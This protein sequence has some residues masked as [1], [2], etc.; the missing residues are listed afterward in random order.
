MSLA[1]INIQDAGQGVRFYGQIDFPTEQPSPAEQVAFY[2]AAH[3]EQIAKE[4][5][6]WYSA[7]RVALKTLT[8]E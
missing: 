3:H 1:R 8:K 5:W 4:S 6:A 2:L 7:Q